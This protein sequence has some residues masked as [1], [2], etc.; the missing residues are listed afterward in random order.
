[1]TAPRL[2]QEQQ[3]K[4]MGKWWVV[5]SHTWQPE[6]V[7]LWAVNKRY[8]HCVVVDSCQGREF[9]HMVGRGGA[10]PLDRHQAR[11]P[12]GTNAAANATGVR[13]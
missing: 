9:V 3:W 4:E 11:A 2:G 10:G 5:N 7:A 12:R 8:G 6:C 13:S 1:M